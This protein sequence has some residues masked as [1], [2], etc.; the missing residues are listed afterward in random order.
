MGSSIPL[1]LRGAGLWVVE[2][3]L[4]VSRAVGHGRW[5]VVGGGLEPGESAYQACQRE[6]REEVGV[7]VRC[8]RLAMV[9][10]IVIR[11]DERLEQDVCFY[12][13]VVAAGEDAVRAGVASQEPGLEIEWI[14]LRE[15]ERA[16]LVP[17]SLDVLIPRALASAD[18]LY[19]TYDC[20]QDQDEREGTYVWP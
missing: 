5:G 6:F 10:D 17:P 20:R 1:R 9:G 13:V 12:F 3:H 11:P 7:D 18:T 14:P 4:L 8:E 19:V 2:D 15:L 16:P